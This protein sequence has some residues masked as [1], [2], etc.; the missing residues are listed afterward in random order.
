MT[1]AFY[2][3]LFYLSEGRAIWVV[4]NK[5]ETTCTSSCNSIILYS[6][7]AFRNNIQNIEK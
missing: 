5:R 6:T 7:H 1:T 4:V 2:L 3:Q